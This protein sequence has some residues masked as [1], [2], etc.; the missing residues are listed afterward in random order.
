M[1]SPW[2]RGKRKLLPTSDPPS[3]NRLGQKINKG[4]QEIN[5]CIYA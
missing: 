3:S 5:E 2:T 4:Q 1:S